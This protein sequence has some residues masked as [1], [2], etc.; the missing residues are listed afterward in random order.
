MLLIP[1]IFTNPFTKATTLSSQFLLLK[2]R[3]LRCASTFWQA[4]LGP[5]NNCPQTHSRASPQQQNSSTS[6]LMLLAK[7]CSEPLNLKSHLKIF[8]I[9]LPKH[10][11]FLYNLPWPGWRWSILI[12]IPH[13]YTASPFTF[14]M[15]CNIKFL[16]TIQLRDTDQQPATTLGTGLV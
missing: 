13:P 9:T 10:K 6:A 1:S 5:S 14:M 11:Y 2:P 8:F 4:L 16:K 12:H 15:I 3:V 7:Q